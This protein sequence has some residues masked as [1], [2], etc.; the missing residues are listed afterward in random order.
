MSKDKMLEV[1]KE[2]NFEQLNEEVD[3]NLTRVKENTKVVLKKDELKT[4][5]KGE[6]KRYTSYKKINE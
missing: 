2:L 5:N 6:K 3:N 1:A 4:L